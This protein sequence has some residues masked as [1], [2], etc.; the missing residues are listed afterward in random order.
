MQAWWWRI[1][2]LPLQIVS[3]NLLLMRAIRER[4]SNTL[5]LFVIIMYVLLLNS[6][7][8]SQFNVLFC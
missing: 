7:L 5:L 4:F 8:L 1:M 6:R 2:S 3:S